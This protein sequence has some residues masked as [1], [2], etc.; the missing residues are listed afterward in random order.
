MPQALRHWKNF[1]KLNCKPS[2]YLLYY[3]SSFSAGKK[4]GGLR[5]MPKTKKTTTNTKKEEASL[6]IMETLL[7]NSILAKFKK[8]E[9]IEGR[10]IG[11]SRNNVTFD[12][13]AKAYAVLGNRELK[14]IATY[15][16]YLKVGDNIKVR[17][18]AEESK[19]GFPVVS[20]KKFFEKGKWDIL[21]EKKETEQEIDV[22]CGEYGKGG[23]FIEFM[24]IRGVIP[25]IQLTEEYLNTPE[26]LQGQRI[27]V[28]ILEVDE[29]KNR[30]VVSQKASVL[31]ISQK[32]LKKRFDDIETGKTY[33]A[34]VLGGSEFGIFCDI[35]GVEGLVHISE[36]SWQ[37]VTDV[38]SYIQPG[39]TID[40]T[41]VEKNEADL[42]LNLSIKRLTHDPWSDIEKKYPQDK[43]VEGELI[44]KERYG[45]FVRLEPGIEGLIH[46]SKLNGKEDL[47]I[48][49]KIKAYIEKVDSKNRRMSL[50]LAQKEKPVTYR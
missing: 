50:L 39:E 18:V 1:P 4:R 3:K 17:V 42:K 5:Q 37:K 34:H 6:N 28:K 21:K 22:V 49:N 25:K 43:E 46:I 47:Q 38:S 31:K 27:K 40:V 35:N 45:F 30:L 15:F 29:A 36:I 32:E 14:E 20:L 41:I 23:V 11:L 10:I 24:G 16:P 9:E 48:G 7:K 44:R 8:G 13:G 12:I 33:K 2:N 26:K 19:D